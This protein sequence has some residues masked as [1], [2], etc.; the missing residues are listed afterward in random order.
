M[1]RLYKYAVIGCNNPYP[2]DATLFS[3]YVA[4]R[5]YFLLITD[6]TVVENDFANQM[7]F[8]FHWQIL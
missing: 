4:M 7:G 5:L 6:N 2:H 8:V 3:M 1:Q